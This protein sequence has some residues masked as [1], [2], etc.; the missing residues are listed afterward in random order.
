MAT[1]P[2][3]TNTTLTSTTA[4]TGRWDGSTCKW[5]NRLYLVQKPGAQAP[6]VYAKLEPYG[7]RWTPNRRKATQLCWTKAR[8][9]A[10]QEQAFVE[11][12]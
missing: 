5:G 11:A 6:K 10:R 12:A 1:P 9:L 4:Y 3:P 8:K 7:V 2:L